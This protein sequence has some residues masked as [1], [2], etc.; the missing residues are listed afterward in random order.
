MIAIVPAAGRGTRMQAIT[1]GLPKEL[2]PLGSIPV[3]L[4]VLLEARAVDPDEIVIVTRRDKPQIDEAVQRWSLDPLADVP[5]R[6]TYQEHATGAGPAIAE[7]GA[8]DDAVVLFADCVFAPESPVD[9]L[10]NLIAR[11]VDGVVSVETVPDSEV[12]RYGIVELNEGT[13]AVKLIKEKPRIEE[14]ASRWAVAARFAFSKPALGFLSDY[15]RFHA[16]PGRPEVP[17]TQVM[18]AM[19]AQGIDVRAAPLTDAQCRVDCGSPEEY[20]EAME[21]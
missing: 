19:V 10:A 4:R 15:C 6:V 13:G 7:A 5:I 12:S 2:V 1:N 11:G 21:R 8:D 20:R 14:T 3:L 9:R 16:A 18:N 17:I